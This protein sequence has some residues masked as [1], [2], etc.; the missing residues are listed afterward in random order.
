MVYERDVERRGC[1]RHDRPTIPF[2]F[3]KRLKI[4]RGRLSRVTN[5]PD[6]C[7]F[8]FLPSLIFP[9]IIRF[10]DVTTKLTSSFVALVHGRL[11]S[12]VPPHSLFRK[13]VTFT[14]NTVDDQ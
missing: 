11:K 13:I 10:N 12:I 8:F 5:W 6:L 14:K 7:N 4:V 3:T 2:S 1:K 9:E